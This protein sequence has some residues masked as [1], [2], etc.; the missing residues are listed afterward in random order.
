MAD[1]FDFT[2]FPVLCTP[3]LVLRQLIPEDAAAVFEIRGDY[4]VTRLNIG[5]AYT[6]LGQ[7]AELID[8]ITAGYRQGIELRWG[9]ALAGQPD[10]VIGMVGYNEWNRRDRRGSVGYDLARDY[11]GLGI[12]PEALREALR[13]GFG[14]MGL[15]RVE[16]DASAENTASSRV[17]EKLGFGLEGRQRQQY[18]DQG[19]FH[20]LLLYGLLKAEFEAAELLSKA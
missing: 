10:W 17:L 14:R 8:S 5:P 12:M 19:A 7:A 2:M 16:A 4:Q 20:D 13:F 1:L 9:I 11:W 6:H 18:F 15:N 3:R